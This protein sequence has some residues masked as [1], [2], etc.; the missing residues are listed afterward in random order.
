MPYQTSTNTTSSNASKVFPSM[1]IHGLKGFD[2]RS[3]MSSIC[4]TKRLEPPFFPIE[5]VGILGHDNESVSWLFLVDSV[6]ASK[7]NHSS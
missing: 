3:Q 4:R 7:L 1:S 2:L 5:T 6:P